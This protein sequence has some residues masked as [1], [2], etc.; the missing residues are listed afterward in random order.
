MIKKTA[1]LIALLLI[2]PAT[3]VLATHGSVGSGVGQT[4]PITTISA[5]TLGKGKWIFDVQ[6]EY[7]KY[8]EFSDQELMKFAARGENVHSVKYLLSVSA[9]IAYGFTD[10]FTLELRMPYVRRDNIKESHADEPDEVHH[11]GDAEGFGD[12]KAIGYYRLTHLLNTG[13]ETTVIAGLKMPTGKT[14]DRDVE[15]QVFEAEFQPGSGS[16][17]PIL[18]AAVSKRFGDV[19]LDANVLYTFVTEGTQDTDLGDIFNYNL[20]VSYRVMKERP[21]L[22]LSLELNGIWRDKQKVDGVKDSNSGGNVLFLSPGLRIGWAHKVMGYFSVGVPIIDNPYG[23]QNDTEVRI[24][25]G[26]SFLF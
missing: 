10:D 11:H 1:V 17:D 12:L 19:S 9:G 3:E 23:I 14:N 8:D 5:Y 22:D 13:V 26:L 15:G 24:V 25:G 2:L 18:G 20:A 16:W 6:S 4:G 7:I 21:S